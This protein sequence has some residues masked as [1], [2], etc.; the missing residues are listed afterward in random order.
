MHIIVQ[1]GGR[2]AKVG[3]YY[4]FSNVSVSC[5]GRPQLLPP[6]GISVMINLMIAKLLPFLA[7]GAIMTL[8]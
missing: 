1:R 7:A 3:R 5:G 2:W 8:L 4:D 6:I